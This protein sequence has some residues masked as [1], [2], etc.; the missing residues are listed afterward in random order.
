[1]TEWPNGAV[2]I[3]FAAITVILFAPRADQAYAAAMSFMV[4][5]ALA[6]VFAAIVAFAVLPG[7]EAFAGLQHRH[8]LYLVPA[9][10]LMA[11]PGRRRCL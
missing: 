3:T 10:A 9:G 5:I 4:G 1:M 2:A 6:T 8:W 11:R 7:L